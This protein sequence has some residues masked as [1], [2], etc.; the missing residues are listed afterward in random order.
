MPHLNMTDN[1]MSLE[2]DISSAASCACESINSKMYAATCFDNH[3]YGLGLTVM[4]SQAFTRF[5]L[6]IIPLC[7]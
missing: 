5:E 6:P 2:W 1:I 7:L 3:M 4:K